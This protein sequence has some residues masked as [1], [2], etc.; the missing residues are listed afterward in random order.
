[1]VDGHRAMCHRIGLRVG[2]VMITSDVPY[3]GCDLGDIDVHDSLAMDAPASMACALSRV[4]Q[5]GVEC[6]GAFLGPP[7]HGS[8]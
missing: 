3:R 7:S 8:I 6:G 1:M 2:S 5:L 4:G